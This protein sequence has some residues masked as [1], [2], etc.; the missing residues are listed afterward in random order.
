MNGQS[1]MLL[2][3]GIDNAIHQ[4]ERVIPAY[5]AGKLTEPHHPHAIAVLFRRLGA[6]RLLTTGE[7]EPLLTAQMQSASAYLH[8]LPQVSEE[9]KVTSR[10]GAW[11]D[12]I[13][14]EYWEAAFEIARH[15]RS[16]PNPTWE[17]EDDF[18]F[19]WFLMT[20]YFLDDGGVAAEQRQRLLLDRWDAVLAGAY[21]PRRLLCDSLLRR[22]PRGFH[23]SLAEVGEHREALLR[24]QLSER[25][26]PQEDAV[27]TL[28]F[29]PEGLA[30]LRLAE[31]D[32]MPIDAHQRGV[33]QVVQG[34]NPYEYNG[35]AWLDIEYQPSPRRC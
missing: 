13:G 10:A 8:R 5:A 6:C 34:P 31:R 2:H 18:L 12:A 28:P 7:A 27:W 20:R 16:A 23:A 24:Q 9:D 22:D 26:L 17:H 1:S 29:W 19:V 15:S 4:L 30:L 33:P 11:W 25:Q 21:D 35:Q 14:G 3:A 32:G